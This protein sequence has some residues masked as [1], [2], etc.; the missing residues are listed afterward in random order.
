MLRS[1]VAAVLAVALSPS[2]ATAQI[3]ETT[4]LFEV[5]Q[6]PGGASREKA[7]ST[8]ASTHVFEKA[9]IRVSTMVDAMRAD[10]QLALYAAHG[11]LQALDVLTTSH[12]LATGQ[13]E[14][15]PLFHNGNRSSMIATKA[16]AFALNL[17]VVER[18][19]GRRPRT[20]RWVMIATNAW[21]SMVVTNNIA[22]AR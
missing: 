1:A 22:V 13:R 18:L 6:F 2:I 21:M 12:A 3:L 10:P 14:A 4:Q 9:R 16:A 20:A 11:T 7:E 19:A 15:N 5:T 17:Y 8:G